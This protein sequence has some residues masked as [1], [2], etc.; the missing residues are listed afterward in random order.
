MHGC[1]NGFFSVH[2]SFILKEVVIMGAVF[3]INSILLG[4]ALAMDA[5]S[6]SIANGLGDPHMKG[7]KMSVVAGT[8]AFFQFAMPMLGWAMVHFL[9][10]AF[11]V[12]ELFIPWIAL[13]LLTFLGIKMIVECIAENEEARL[14]KK[15]KKE[16]K[17]KDLTL[18]LLLTQGIAT[19]IDAL[20]VGLTI[21]GYG[22]LE[23]FVCSLIIA[24]VTF[25]LCMGGLYIGK[26]VGKKFSY[27]GVM[28]GVIL[29]L[30]GLEICITALL[31]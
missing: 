19:S 14:T 22:V 1:R 15:E 7:G 10:Q 9:V 20:S 4:I 21:E 13:G 6:V 18:S 17:A 28:G 5:F 31:G 30:I 2:R 23:A 29:I 8:Y 26:T 24:T 3:Y 12:L 11:R 27:A 16:E 25:G